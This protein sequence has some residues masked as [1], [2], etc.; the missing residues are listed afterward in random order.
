MGKRLT[1]A[2]AVFALVAVLLGT[3]VAGYLW[4]G[5]R[6]DWPSDEVGDEVTVRLYH[7]EW[8]ATVFRPAGTIESLASG[9]KVRIGTAR[10][11]PLASGMRH[12]RDRG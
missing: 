9:V 10:C 6:E 7:R 5:E 8:Q 11:Q 2:L 4:L 1:L 3:Y 12:H